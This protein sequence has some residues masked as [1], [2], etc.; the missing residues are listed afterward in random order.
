MAFSIDQ[1]L[2]EALPVEVCNDS[3][4]YFPLV[5]GRYEVKPRLVTFGT[6]FGNEAADRQVF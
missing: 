3:A 1:L 5:H 6:D 2:Q 4:Y